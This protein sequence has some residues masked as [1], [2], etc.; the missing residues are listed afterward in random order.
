MPAPHFLLTPLAG[1]RTRG[2]SL[3][4]L[5][6]LG[7]DCAAIFASHQHYGIMFEHFTIV[8]I[9]LNT[10]AFVLST[11]KTIE[12]YVDECRGSNPIHAN[13]KFYPECWTNVK[14]AYTI[15]QWVTTVVFTIEFLFRLYGRG[16]LG[17]IRGRLRL[18]FSFWG[19]VDM[20]CN[21][22]FFID[23]IIERD[24]P[25][26]QWIRSLRIFKSMN[27]KGRFL[28]AFRSLTKIFKVKSKLLLSTAFLGVT[29]WLVTS[30]LY[31]LAE[32]DNED[33]VVCVNDEGVC[34]GTGAADCAEG[35]FRMHR[36]GDIPNA[37]FYTV[38]V[39]TRTL[40]LPTRPP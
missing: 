17:A 38:S 6:G 19:L 16:E 13:P 39:S 9:T 21:V 10:L 40:I 33:M 24:L 7:R 31:Y 22:P 35:G 32:K 4:I 1:W 26:F 18:V 5:P 11:E 25:A 15:I 12:V 3:W 2:R 36:Y 28:Y 27:Q 8:L 34:G 14:W 30:S 37:M 29:V 23:H 20:M